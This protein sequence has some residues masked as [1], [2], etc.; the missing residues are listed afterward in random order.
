M[1]LAGS[2][3]SGFEG[4]G[5][6]S[7]YCGIRGYSFA[8]RFMGWARGDF[9]KL[10]GYAGHSEFNE[11]FEVRGE[12][13]APYGVR[14]RAQSGSASRVVLVLRAARMG[15]FSHNLHR[16]YGGGWPTLLHALFVLSP[17]CNQSAA[18]SSLLGKKRR[19]PA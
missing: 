16:Y 7:S 9:V 1:G 15:H 13:R 19:F 6:R 12:H 5:L 11:Y 8:V 3:G 2:F 14:G 10:T 4:E 18:H 17:W